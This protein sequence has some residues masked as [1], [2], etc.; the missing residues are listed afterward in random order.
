M[1]V[2]A[3]ELAIAVI[4]MGCG[5]GGSGDTTTGGATTGAS[6]G[7]STTSGTGTGTGTAT[8]G[9]SC[10]SCRIG[11]SCVAGKCQCDPTQCT[12]NLVCNT[13]DRCVYDA[14]RLMGSPNDGVSCLA[15]SDCG[16]PLFCLK[17]DGGS[18]GSCQ[19]RCNGTADCPLPD[20][21]CQGGVCAV[22]TCGD[23]GGNGV[24]NGPCNA[25]GQNDGT[26][27]PHSETVNG[28]T[29]V[30]G[31]CVQNGCAMAG[32]R[33]DATRNE[34][35]ALCAAGLTCVGQLPNPGLCYRLCE[36][37]A[38]G[39]CGPTQACQQGQA[40]D[41][42]VTLCA[43]FQFQDAGP[44]CL[45]SVPD[46]G[47]DGG[48]D[49]HEPYSLVPLNAGGVVLSAV[50]LTTIDYAGYELD[51]D[52][53]D[54]ATWIVGSDWF[55]TVG[56]DYGVG[57]GTHVQHYTINSPAPSSLTGSDI[58]ALLE[59]LL[60]VD[61]GLPPPNENSLYLIYFPASTTITGGGTSCVDYGGY[62][63]EDVAGSYDVPYGVIPTCSSDLSVVVSHEIAESVTDPFVGSRPA[64]RFMNP[65]D[66]FTY[67]SQGEVGDLC[68][69]LIGTYDGNHAAQRIWS[70]EAAA[71]GLGSPC[72]PVPAD[73]IFVNL[74]PLFSGIQPVSTGA[75]TFRLTG[76]SNNAGAAGMWQIS[77]STLSGTNTAPTLNAS[78]IGDGQSVSLTITFPPSATVGEQ[79]VV[80]VNS[81]EPVSGYSN[82][83]PMIFQI[84]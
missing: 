47:P 13:N 83:W 36:M 56:H 73:E 29:V 84:Q 82:Y 69:G 4:L 11:E 60:G 23:D 9:G 40:R 74:T 18:A 35:Y 81:I 44:T 15:N 34:G 43:P 71:A 70:N 2:V 19:R 68:Q 16:C 61:G 52:I 30:T 20:T 42:M 45:P 57:L 65:G 78:T 32:C 24:L 28:H 76:W 27:V 49:W 12:G 37:D 79:T 53:Q 17:A 1:R 48:D 21:S 80:E 59:S 25:L 38:G 41:P 10:S 8:T 67:V 7:S 51:Q 22:T 63:T 5:G 58:D 62:H 6:T 75:T 31:S 77:A 54:Y 26:C 50:E 72:A 55:A 3:I 46:A 14:C 64:Y 33:L 39:L 66:A